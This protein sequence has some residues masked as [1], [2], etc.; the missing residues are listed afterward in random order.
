M[1]KVL[2]AVFMLLLLAGCG[3]RSAEVVPKAPDYADP[4]M[5]VTRDGDP[6]ENGADV[7]YVVSTWEEDWTDPKGRTVHYADVWN[8]GHRERMARE[9]NKVADYMAPGTASTPRSTGTRR[10]KPG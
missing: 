10:W 6:Q 5:W 1:K 2:T 7:F 4:T 8:P 3:K 9:I